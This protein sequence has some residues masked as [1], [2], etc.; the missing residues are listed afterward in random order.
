MFRHHAA[1]KE[2]DL[3]FQTFCDLLQVILP[4]MEGL[5]LRELSSQIS[6][7]ILSYYYSIL[8]E[9]WIAD[10]GLQTLQGVRL[11]IMSEEET[12]Q[13]GIP[14]SIEWFLENK[15]FLQSYDSTLHPPP[16]FPPRFDVKYYWYLLTE[17][18]FMVYMSEKLKPLYCVLCFVIK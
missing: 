9:R 6:V 16:A 1:F 4:N 11:Q 3:T 2:F 5:S 17:C 7:R 10:R 18:R 14:E 15:A 13:M 8:R 12:P